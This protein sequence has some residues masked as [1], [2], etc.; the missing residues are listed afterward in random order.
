MLCLR[1]NGGEA[2]LTKPC[3]ILYDDQ[4]LFSPYG[5]TRS[6]VFQIDL[7][8][9]T[10]V[11]NHALNNTE[12]DVNDNKIS[13]SPNKIDLHR[14]LKKRHMIMIALGGT[15]DTGL[16]LASG[17]VLASS[18]PDGSFISYV[19]VS[20]MVYLVMTTKLSTQYPISGSFSTYGSRFVD[21][22]FGFALGYNYILLIGIGGIITRSIAS[23]FAFGGTKTV[24]ITAGESANPRRDVP[25][26]MKET[27]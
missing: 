25:R 10:S 7:I 17:Q 13:L 1:A 6:N 12:T 16:F 15:I 11:N 27:I 5:K 23:S 14:N 21:E 4:H 9:K 20:I 8:L 24:S 18:G 19:V 26:A 22:A 2:S 3:L